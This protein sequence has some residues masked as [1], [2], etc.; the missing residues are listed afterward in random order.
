MKQVFR[1]GCLNYKANDERGFRV[2]R[3]GNATWWAIALTAALGASLLAG[4]N[5]KESKGPPPQVQTDANKQAP[6]GVQA[7]SGVQTPPDQAEGPSVPREPVLPGAVAV[8]V[9]NSPGARPQAGLDRADLV[10]EMEAEGGITRFLTFFYQYRA[11]KIGPV[12]SAR[13]GFL[14]VASAYGVPYAH[15]GGSIEAR[16]ALMKGIHRLLNIDEVYTCAGCFWRSRD[17]SAPHNAYTSTDL[18]IG[19]AQKV[20]F[21]LHPLA[22]FPEGPMETE[23]KRATD[24]AFSWGPG[25]QEVAWH[26]N[27]KRYSRSQSGQP[28]LLEGGAQVEADNLILLFTRYVW[29]PKAPPEGLYRIGIIGSGEGYLY[30]EGQVFPILW[31]KAGRGDHYRFTTTDG[32]P[33]LLAPGQTWVEVLKLKSHVVQGIP[34]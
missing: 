17:R 8:M 24:I 23:G 7:P 25:T 21:V 29:D 32:K 4:C 31:S 6:P 10:Y 18:L 20:G 9:E 15:V 19:R 5:A 30:R 26:W 1:P 22:R 11:D 34:Q 33:V 3:S 13:M 2:K 12:R 16:E 14:D 28:H 27:G